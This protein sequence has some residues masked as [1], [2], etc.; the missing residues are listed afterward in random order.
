[1]RCLEGEE[2]ST[3]FWEVSRPQCCGRGVG[4]QRSKQYGRLFKFAQRLLLMS[5]P[6]TPKRSNVG[7]K[8]PKLPTFVASSRI[9]MCVCGP[10]G[11]VSSNKIV[12]ERLCSAWGR[13][14]K[15]LEPRE[16]CG[17]ESAPGCCFGPQQLQP[18]EQVNGRAHC[19]RSF[20][21]FLPTIAVVVCSNQWVVE[22]RR[23]GR[24]VNNTF[25]DHIRPSQD[26]HIGNVAMAGAAVARHHNCPK[27]CPLRA[28]GITASTPPFLTR[29]RCSATPVSSALLP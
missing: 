1:M 18:A 9:G 17:R 5:I 2:G 26:D 28:N 25:M 27:L 7:R 21:L 8:T 3:S 11:V 6:H 29:P 22:G 10:V 16:P 15:C 19:A 12:W 20:H 24:H 13:W 4:E 14:C 23:P